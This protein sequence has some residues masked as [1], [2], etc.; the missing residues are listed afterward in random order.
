MEGLEGDRR[1]V[2]GLVCLCYKAG[3]STYLRQHG[4]FSSII[5]GQSLILMQIAINVH[6]IC[7]DFWNTLLLFI[8]WNGIV[9]CLVASLFFLIVTSITNQPP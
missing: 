4:N 5:K 3:P 8:Q 9:G 2:I 1:L 6:V 7:Q